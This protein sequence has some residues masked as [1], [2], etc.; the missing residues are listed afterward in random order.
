[1]F[2][3]FDTFRYD[4]DKNCALKLYRWLQQIYTIERKKL[5]KNILQEKKANRKNTKK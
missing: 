3:T 4:T 2:N 1:M 5:T